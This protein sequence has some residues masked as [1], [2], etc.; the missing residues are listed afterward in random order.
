M[1]DFEVGEIPSVNLGVE[2]RDQL[3][4]LINT[5]GYSSVSLEIRGSDNEKV[6]VTGVGVTPV[7]SA[8]GT[9]VVEWPKN[10]SLFTRKGKYLMRFALRKS[11]GSVDYTRPEE[12]R[13]R[14]YGRLYN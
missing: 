10:R 12:I 3:D 14:D 13:V 5:L 2:V 7:S 6:D 9:F 1:I 8:T 4:N 11:D